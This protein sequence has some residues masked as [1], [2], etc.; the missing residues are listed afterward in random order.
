MI[1][2]TQGLAVLGELFIYYLFASPIL[3]NVFETYSYILQDL[4]MNG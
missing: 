2:A 4:N 3:V 1:E